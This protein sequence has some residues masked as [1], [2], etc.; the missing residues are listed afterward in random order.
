MSGMGWSYPPG[1]EGTPD[2][3]VEQDMERDADIHFTD[4]QKLY[5]ALD[6]LYT[7]VSDEDCQI[8][9]ESYSAVT[10]A[11]TILEE[12]KQYR[13]HSEERDMQKEM[14]KL[15]RSTLT[16]GLTLCAVGFAISFAAIAKMA[17]DLLK[18]WLRDRR[19][20]AEVRRREKGRLTIKVVN[21]TDQEIVIRQGWDEGGTIRVLYIGNPRPDSLDDAIDVEIREQLGKKRETWVP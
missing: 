15:P 3:D 11:A 7:R 4:A 13:D 12:L 18:E 2:D 16:T 17:C 21:D 6:W 5:E 20:E 9:D 1:C 14:R 8:S 19:V 10:N